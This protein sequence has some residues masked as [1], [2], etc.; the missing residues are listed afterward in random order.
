[1]HILKKVLR[2]F[3]RILSLLKL[4]RP[5]QPFPQE[6]SRNRRRHHDLMRFFASQNFD[7]SIRILDIGCGQGAFLLDLKKQGYQNLFGCDWIDQKFPEFEYQVVDL[8]REGLAKYKAQDF[9][10]ILCSDVIEHLERPAELLRE[11]KRLLKT[12]GQVF[13]TFPNCANLFERFIYLLTGNSSRYQSE[14]K[15]G[16]HGHISYLPTHVMQ[17]L[18]ARADLKIQEFRGGHVYFFGYFFAEQG[19]PLWSYVVNYRLKS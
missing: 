8:N 11:M 3:F 13:L 16:P 7:K 12:G 5:E 17:S 4:A 6:W 14:L 2:F 10:V 9:D 18:A 15:S 1:M 19:S